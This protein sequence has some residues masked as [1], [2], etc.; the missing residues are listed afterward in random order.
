M[1]K[2][3]NLEQLKAERNRIKLQQE[4]LENKIRSNWRDLKECLRPANI[5]KDMIGSFLKSKTEKN[6]DEEDL[7]K[8]S[9]TYGVSLLVKKLADKAW[10][11]LGKIFTN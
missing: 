11:K 10:E 7:F 8:S 2:I 9:I 4:E 3:R 5:A 6:I 1:K